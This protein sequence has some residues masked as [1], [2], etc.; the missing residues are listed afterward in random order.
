MNDNLKST[1]EPFALLVGG[2]F[3]PE[4]LGN[5]GDKF[6]DAIVKECLRIIALHA[7]GPTGDA[8]T[9]DYAIADQRIM[10]V[11]LAIKQRFNINDTN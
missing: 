5:T 4:V 1:Y 2:S 11:Y 9:K 8:Y 3:Y 10:E 6:A 7:I